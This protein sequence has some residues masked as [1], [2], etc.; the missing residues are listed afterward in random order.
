MNRSHLW[1]GGAAVAVLLGCLGCSAS[2]PD[3]VPEAEAL[4]GQGK[5]EEAAAKFEIACANRPDDAKCP[6]SGER[7]ARARLKAAEK[8]M[9]EGLY[10]DAEKTLL[11]AFL[12]AEGAVQ[13]E[14]ADKL[15]GA[16]LKDGLRYQRAL[17]L[18]DKALTQKTLDEIA[19]SGAPA[20]QAKAKEWLDKERPALLIAAV[21]DACG[22]AHKGSCTSAFA[23]LKEAGLKGPEADE[24]AAIAEEEE[25]RVYPKRAEAERFLAVFATQKTKEDGV[26]KCVEEGSADAPSGRTAALKGTCWEEAFGTDWYQAR[27]T[28]ENLW[29]RLMKTIAD[30][31]LVAALEARKREA[32]STGAVQKLDIPKP[33]AAPKKP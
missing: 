19:A 23:K 13:N 17:L 15:V 20:V 4:E 33:K 1:A 11:R 14:I 3:V 27:K 7:A 28:N 10:I 31:D 29:R 26:E 25:R 12:T 21:K 32:L 9:A 16:E 6:S 8:S 18:A 22:P 24:A 30:P 2:G 5:F